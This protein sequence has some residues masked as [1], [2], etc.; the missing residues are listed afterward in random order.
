[1]NTNIFL[2]GFMGTGKTTL[3]RMLA[4][5]TGMNF[6]DLDTKIEEHTGKTIAKIFDDEGEVWFRKKE[7][8]VLTE[9]IADS[10]QVFSTGGGIVLNP[11]NVELMK[12]KGILISLNA[13]VDTLWDRLKNSTARPLLN[14]KNPKEALKRLYQTRRG[15][16]NN[17]HILIKVDDRSPEELT[18]EILEKI[19]LFN[20]AHLW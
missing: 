10:N 19:S 17:A 12:E 9:Y 4:N 16:Y 20:S 14:N 13:N 5:R 15:L 11:F 2:I 6:I 7:T 3:G 1:V 18:E 8:E